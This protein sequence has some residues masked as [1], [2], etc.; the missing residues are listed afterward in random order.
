MSGIR[1]IF[2]LDDVPVG[3]DCEIA[4]LVFKIAYLGRIDG[5]VG[6]SEHYSFCP[7]VLI[8]ISLMHYKTVK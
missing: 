6:G 7:V 1:I 3:F 4:E 5:V 8:G 2:V